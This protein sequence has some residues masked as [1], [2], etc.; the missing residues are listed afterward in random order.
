[1]CIAGQAPYNL[2][3]QQIWPNALMYQCGTD[4]NLV[5]LNGFENA[6]S[7]QSPNTLLS[8]LYGL[9]CENTAAKISVAV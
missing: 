7:A 5:L 1:M 4:V 8:Y 6:P 3:N 2:T 9:I